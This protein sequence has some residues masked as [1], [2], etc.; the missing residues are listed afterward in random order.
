MRAMQRATLQ[1]RRGSLPPLL[2][3]QQ[4]EQEEETG[5]RTRRL[6]PVVLKPRLASCSSSCRRFA[7]L[8]GDMERCE[9]KIGQSAVLV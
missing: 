2:R 6:Q 5:R 8:C 4:G 9:G 1:P 7:A 3:V